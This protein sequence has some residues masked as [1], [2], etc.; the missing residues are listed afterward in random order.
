MA[1]HNKRSSCWIDLN[2]YV[3]DVTRYIATHPAGTFC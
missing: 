2:G 3:Y 1:L